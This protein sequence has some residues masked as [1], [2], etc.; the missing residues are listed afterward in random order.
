MRMTGDAERLTLNFRRLSDLLREAEFWAESG[1]SVHIGPQHIEKAVAEKERRAG[2]VRELGL[3]TIQ[4]GTVMIDTDGARIG[5]INAL[6]V[7]QIG[8]Y[9]FGKPSRLTAR[10]RPGTGKLVDIERETELGGPIHS[11]GMLILQ[12][13]LAAAY[14]T[15]APLSLWA[16]LVFE[17]S[18]G[19]VEGDSASAAELIALLSSLAEVPLDQSFA[20]TGS[21]NQFGDIQAIG[22]VNQKIEGFFDVCAARGLTGR[23]GVL[24]PAANVR[25]LTLRQRVVDAVEAGRFRIFPMTSVTDGIAVLTG[26]EAGERGAD[27]VF[28]EGSLNRRVEER[29][30]GFAAIRKSFAKEA[31][32]NAT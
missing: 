2:R 7:L 9:S 15:R 10:T 30:Q 22:G 5:Q 26:L 8:D 14:A 24:I 12:G 17:Q 23:Q 4:Q 18:Y 28:P 31:S 11:K 29:L 1:G 27:G 3:E 6:S 19:G 16:S 20:I 13:Y 25:N 32:G 21:V